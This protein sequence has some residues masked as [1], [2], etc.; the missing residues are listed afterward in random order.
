VRTK[1]SFDDARPSPK[2]RRLSTTEALPIITFVTGNFKKLL[3]VKQIL[4]IGDETNGNALPFAM[5][6]HKLDLPELQGEPVEIAVEKCKLAA[7]QVGG[8][9]I[10]EDTSLCFNALQ[11]LPGPYIKWFLDKNGH[12]GL[13]KMLDGFSDRSAYAQTIVCFCAGPDKEPAV[14]DGRTNGKIVRP[15]GP[16]NFGW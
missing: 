1:S 16:T 6:H 11:G 14:F 3:E 8:A 13:N 10:T 15:R 5:E 4:G 12:E 9:V 2:K 7:A